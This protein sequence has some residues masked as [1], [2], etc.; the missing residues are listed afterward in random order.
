VFAVSAPEDCD[1]FM[2]LLPDQP[3]EAEQAVAFIADQ[4]RVELVPFVTVLGAALNVTIG[5]AD[6]T[7]TV[8]DCV[9]LPPE[10]VHVR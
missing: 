2:G 5:D 3:P 9:A 8:A 6:V 10:P 4:A 7:E 1:P